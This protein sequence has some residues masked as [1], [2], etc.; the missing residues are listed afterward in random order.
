MVHSPSFDPDLTIFNLPSLVQARSTGTG[1]SQI[2]TFYIKAYGKQTKQL[3]EVASVEEKWPVVRLGTPL[4]SK[5]A[6]C[7]WTDFYGHYPVVVLVAEGIGITPWMA[8]LQSLAIGSSDNNNDYHHLTTTTQHVHLVWTVRDVAMVQALQQDIQAMM[9]SSKHRNGQ[10]ELNYHIYVTG[11]EAYQPQ[12]DEN[13]SIPPS[14]SSTDQPSQQRHFHQHQGRPDYPALLE[15]IRLKHDG[16]DVALGLCAHEKSVQVCGN[17][18]R[19]SRFS[20]GKAYWN[21]KCE[22][23]DL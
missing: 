5:P 6:H 16:I 22:R 14:S 23:F 12:I 13:N 20:N 21:V 1:E 17:S 18:A 3:F 10:L 8:V 7:H 9:A 4:G 2:L 15:S 11:T 19:S